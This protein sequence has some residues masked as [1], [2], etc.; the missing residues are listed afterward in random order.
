M[1]SCTIKS[2]FFAKFLLL[3][4]GV[5]IAYALEFDEKTITI[6]GYLSFE[7]EQQWESKDHGPGDAKG[8]FDADLFDL[9]LG[10]AVTE[11]TRVAADVS[12]EHG[13]ATEDGR[14]N[15]A[16]EYGFVEHTVTDLLR[17]RFGKQF[18]PF[19]YFN[20]IHTAKPATL[21]VKE[22]AST[23]KPERI[24]AAATRFYPRWAVGVGLQGDGNI[25]A[26]AWLFAGKK[27]DYNILYSNGEQ[28]DTNPFENDDNKSKA[29]TGRFRLNVRDNLMIGYS[30]Y[31]DK[32]TASS[33]EELESHGLTFDYYYDDSLRFLAEFVRSVTKQRSHLNS[34]RQ[35]GWFLQTSYRLPVAYVPFNLD[36]LTPYLR[37]GYIDPN[38]NRHTDEGYSVIIGFNAELDKSLIL[39]VE[40]NYIHG[41]R[42]S[43][44]GIYPG[45][46]YNEFKIGIVVGF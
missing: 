30:I 12:W 38:T 28:E 42:E 9:V 43:S 23:N 24:V 39:K 41:Q 10:V 3:F 34:I 2:G 16:L 18:V 29:L 35:N 5:S 25:P 8:S 17:F 7:Y 27:F 19:G 31:F 1:G 44:L 32:S 33:F 4:F 11:K 20:E 26:T 6:D 37:Y 13:T 45:H 21:S 36:G 40:N 46:D 22:A 14:G 15:S